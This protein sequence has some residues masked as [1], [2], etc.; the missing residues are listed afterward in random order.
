MQIAQGGLAAAHVYGQKFGMLPLLC[1]LSV[2]VL[3]ELQ[4]DEQ[5]SM[6]AALQEGI[7]NVVPPPPPPSASSLEEEVRRFVDDLMPLLYGM[8]LQTSRNDRRMS[9][10]DIVALKPVKYGGYCGTHGV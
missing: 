4:G 7:L 2:Q 10:A 6:R 3:A 5:K 9:P 8:Y 1:P